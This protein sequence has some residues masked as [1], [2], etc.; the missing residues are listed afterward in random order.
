MDRPPG[1]PFQ[2]RI[3][4]TLLALRGEPLFGALPKIPWAVFLAVALHWGRRGE[5]W[6]S[7]ERLA[8]ITGY[9][10]RAVRA[11][12]ADLE[13][14]GLLVVRRLSTGRRRLRTFYAPGTSTIAEIAA[15]E[16]R[17][18]AARRAGDAARRA[19]VQR[20]GVPGNFLRV[21]NLLLENPA[22]P[23]SSPSPARAG[24]EPRKEEGCEVGEVDRSIAREALREHFERR[25][26]GRRPPRLFDEDDVER[27]ARC[28]LAFDGDAESTRQAMRDALAGAFHVSRRPATT[29]FIWGTLEHFFEHVDRGRRMR[30]EKER[31]AMRAAPIAPGP[32][33]GDPSPPDAELSKERMAS[34]LAALFGDR[35]R[36]R[37]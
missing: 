33:G 9:S 21:E 22:G 10:V 14:R 4:H 7:Q 3:A 24:A 27:V 11:A 29:R 26:P 35:W 20:H 12:L 36:T 1:A 28:A 2:G 37:A 30:H 32:S 6:P 5:A 16:G 8:R 23:P 34:D 31:A 15:L 25:R 13:R 18:D 19:G 17:T